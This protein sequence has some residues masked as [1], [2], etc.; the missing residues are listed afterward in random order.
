MTVRDSITRARA[1]TPGAEDYPT[2]KA[3]PVRALSPT[4]CGIPEVATTC[5]KGRHKP[6]NSRCMPGAGLSWLVSGK[7]LPYT[8]AFQPYRGKPA[9][10]N[11]REGRGNVGIIRSP[12]RA[13]TLPDSGGRE[14][15]RVP[16]AIL[17]LLRLLTAGYG[18][19]CECRFV[20]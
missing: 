14:V 3:A 15:T 5:A 16:T 8:P 18:T 2:S 17:L 12:V 1:R 19:K 4:Q 20:P 13:S 11:D 6:N 10:R 9:V 7:V